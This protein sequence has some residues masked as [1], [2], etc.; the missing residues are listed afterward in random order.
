MSSVIPDIYS[1][2]NLGLFAEIYEDCGTTSWCDLMKVYPLPQ[3]IPPNI[4]PEFTDLLHM[5]PRDKTSGSLVQVLPVEL[6]IL[7]VVF[8]PLDPFLCISTLTPYLWEICS[9]SNV[10]RYYL[11]C[12]VV[13]FSRVMT[14]FNPPQLCFH[15]ELGGITWG[16]AVISKGNR[17]FSGLYIDG[18]KE[19]K[20]CITYHSSF[21]AQHH[22]YSAKTRKVV[23]YSGGIKNGPYYIYAPSID[24]EYPDILLERGSYLKGKINGTVCRYLWENQDNIMTIGTHRLIYSHMKEKI[25]FRAGVKHGPFCIQTVCTL[26]RGTYVADQLHGKY[27]TYNISDVEMDA[28]YP[29]ES[30]TYL[31]G[32]KHGKWLRYRLDDKDFYQEPDSYTAEILNYNNGRLVPSQ[33]ALFT[34]ISNNIAMFNWKKI[35]E[36]K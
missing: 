9:N 29:A 15:Y 27:W 5:Q 26:E 21:H 25:N 11:Q 2:K 17:K 10:I 1:K 3:S 31:N 8:L 14:H 12:N 24:D 19:G 13:K 34:T 32:K 6:W 20:W 30:G 7:I 36:K 23:T 33:K 35:L 4:L 16:P 18:K 28:I 22:F